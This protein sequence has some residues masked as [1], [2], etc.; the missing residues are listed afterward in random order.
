MTRTGG[1]LFLC[2]PHIDCFRVLFESHSLVNEYKCNCIKIVAF[3]PPLNVEG[4]VGSSIVP[5]K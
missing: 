5:L 2:V 1:I 3:N 4:T